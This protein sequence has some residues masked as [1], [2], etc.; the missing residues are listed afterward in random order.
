MDNLAFQTTT[1]KL[2][3]CVSLTKLEGDFGTY[4]KIQE[5]YSSNVSKPKCILVNMKIFMRL[6]IFF[7]LL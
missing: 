6:S 1:T 7:L 5:G 2:K 4:F 3:H